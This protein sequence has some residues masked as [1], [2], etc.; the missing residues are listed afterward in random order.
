MGA[1]SVVPAR[2]TDVEPSSR[3]KLELVS[4]AGS[5]APQAPVFSSPQSLIRERGDD[6]VAVS[7]LSAIA[8]YI[9]AVGFLMLVGLFPAHITGELV[10]L[11][12]ALTAGHPMSHPSRLAVIPIF[13]AALF[14]GAIVTRWRRKAGKS[15]HRALL[16]LMTVALGVSA[17]TGF[18]APQDGTGHVWVFGVRECSVVTAMAFQNAFMRE[19]LANACPTTVM[20]GNLT[21]LAFELVDTVAARLGPERTAVR[22]ASVRFWL[23]ASAL[24]SFLAG[25]IL[26]G[27]LT[28][29]VGV[30]GLVI[31]M[32]AA[33]LL[34][35]RLEPAARHFEHDRHS[36]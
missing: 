18:W 33:F 16:V 7:V 27:F 13:V 9:D 5:L 32:I 4:Y 24:G 2:R 19:G 28:G 23:V 26:G 31:P 35:Q 11:T 30:F 25:A 12:T 8:G 1:S 10:G 34:A 21:Q 36:N 6:R 29:I 22:A 3:S 15:P 17:V 20:T 14:A